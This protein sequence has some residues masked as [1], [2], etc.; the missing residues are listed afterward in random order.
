[1][2]PGTKV[3]SLLLIVGGAAGVLAGLW[4]DAQ[5]LRQTGFR[6]SANLSIVAVFILVFGWSVWVGAWLWRGKPQGYRWAKVLF[7]AQIPIITVPGFSFSLSTGLALNV[8]LDLSPP[9]LHFNFQLESA[10]RFLISGEI[11]NALVGVNLAA[12]L[13]LA[14]LFRVTSPDYGRR[15][16]N[17]GL[18]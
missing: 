18:I 11:A 16:D 5:T 9:I 13:A 2:D 10:M 7:A 3:L 4:G 6:P 17:F 12:I 15:R 14:Y 1:M 8:I